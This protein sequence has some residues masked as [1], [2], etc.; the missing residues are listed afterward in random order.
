[1]P[2]PLPTTV[3]EVKAEIAQAI[4]RRELAIR[5]VDELHV[6]STRLR[7]QEMK[8]QTDGNND[9]RKERKRRQE[10]ERR[11]QELLIE[12]KRLKEAIQSPLAN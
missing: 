1:M 5:E 8:T 3:K 11:V 9:I 4:L 12:N 6:V 10:A 7:L 2:K